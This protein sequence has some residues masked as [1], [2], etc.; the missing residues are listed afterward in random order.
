L[1]A[2]QPGKL[3]FPKPEVQIE[4]SDSLTLEVAARNAETLNAATNFHIDGTGFVSAEAA[5][6][7]A[8]ALRVRLRLLN[9]ILG[10]GLNIP[11]G[12]KISAQV[13][14]EIKNKLKSEQ[15]ATVVDSVW[16]A[17]VFPDDGVHFEYV[18]SGNIGVSPS[19]PAYLLE[20]IKKLWALDISLDKQSEDALQILC[21]ATQETSD[22]AAFLTTYLALEELVDRRPRSDAIKEVLQHF[23]KE[24]SEL[25]ANSAHPLLPEEASSLFGVLGSLNEESFSSALSRLGRQIT[26]PAEICG[27]AIPKFLSACI[28]ARNKIAHHAE[29]ET[30]IP[31]GDLSKALREFVL[32]L[33]WTRNKLPNFTLDTPPSAVSIPP[34]GLSIRVM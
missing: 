10:L 8:E 33:I 12:D 5:T 30:A 2:R 21:L 34:G 24:L 3:P 9:A 31:F 16:G 25:G 29:P 27:L 4:V 19:D 28:D 17:S 26:Q 20:G 6:I 22:K 32:K 15:G 7:A 13:S 23:Q 1:A 11:V 18:V 14:E